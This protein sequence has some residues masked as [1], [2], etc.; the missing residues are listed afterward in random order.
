MTFPWPQ[1]VWNLAADMIQVPANEPDGGGSE[2][3][4]LYRHQRGGYDCI[5]EE[6][7]EPW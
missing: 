2:V 6:C 7:R 1:E 3:G 4:G 5:D